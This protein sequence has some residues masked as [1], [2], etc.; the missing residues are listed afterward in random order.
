MRETHDVT[1]D[2][3]MSSLTDEAAESTRF[4]Q[5]V[6]QVESDHEFPFEARHQGSQ[7]PKVS[8]IRTDG[9]PLEVLNFSAYN[10]LGLGY[11]PQ[12][13][14][15]AK[16]ALDTYGLGAG[17]SPVHSGTFQVHADLE[18]ALLDFYDLP[19]RGVSLFSSGYGVNV[20]TISAM[21]R[22]HHHVVMDRA[23]HMSILEG[24][25]L[26]R[27]KLHYFE[28]N[29]PEDLERVLSGLNDRR[30]LVCTEGVF[31]ADGDYGALK[32]IVRISKKHGAW[33]LVDEAH[34]VGLIGEGGRGVA[35]AAGV[36]EEVDLMVVTFSK[37]FGGVG[38]AVIAPQAMARY[39]NWYARCR[40][41]SCA[42]DPAVSAGV[43]QAIRIVGSEEGALRR[44]RLQAGAARLRAALQG[45]VDLGLSESWIVTVIYGEESL[46]LPL[47]DWLQR[48]GLDVSVLQFPA[49][50]MGEARIRVF[51]SSEHQEA[52]LDRCAELLLQA[53]ERFSFG[54]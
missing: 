46:T 13:I 25:Q 48:E 40:M 6:D 29:D 19:E 1:Y 26:S 36:L 30:T 11:H 7:R 8:L 34:S 38:G 50:P 17:S 45:K 54:V 12:V 28:H 37:A 20:G 22:R 10:Y 39:I 44:T 18:Q 49:V 16:Q 15:A 33:V 42:L 4:Q 31:S 43:A 5:W 21:M 35:Q 52:Q 53:A 24:A 14:A 51:V 41:F 23:A 47:L 32:D 3:F 27:A 9:T 2:M